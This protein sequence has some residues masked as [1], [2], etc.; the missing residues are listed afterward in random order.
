MAE[1]MAG[2]NWIKH[3]EQVLGLIISNDYQPQT[4]EFITPDSYKQQVGFIVYPQD[5][6]IQP[7]VHNKLE[8]KLLGTSEV[9]LVRKGHCHV[10][11]YLDDKSLHSSHELQSGDILV[12]VSGGH[13]FRMI[14]PSVFIEV[15]QG[16]YIGEHEKERF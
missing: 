1:Q 2:I 11:F 9:L 15:K 5:G 13:G 10:D 12:L 8:R 3:E 16:P 6:V 4:T 14:E 7:H